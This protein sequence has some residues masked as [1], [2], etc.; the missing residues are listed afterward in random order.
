MFPLHDV[1]M[2]FCELPINMENKQQTNIHVWKWTVCGPPKWARDVEIWWIIFVSLNKPWNTRVV[3]D[4][5]RHDIQV[6]PLLKEGDV[7]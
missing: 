6:K 2:W 1:I 7:K 5:T 3:D 4:L